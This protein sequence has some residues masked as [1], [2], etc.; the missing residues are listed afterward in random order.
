MRGRH[1][2]TPINTR[3]LACRPGMYKKLFAAESAASTPGRVRTDDP[4][5]KSRTLPP[6]ELRVHD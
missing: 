2:P 4:P 6:T 5:V 3:S 1:L